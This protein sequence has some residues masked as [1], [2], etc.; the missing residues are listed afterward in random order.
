MSQGS[1]KA[2]SFSICK[3][4]KLE[5]VTHSWILLADRWGGWNPWGDSHGS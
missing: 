2:L 1:P 5:L 4:G 3:M